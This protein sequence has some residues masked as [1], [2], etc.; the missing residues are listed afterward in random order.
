MWALSLPVLVHCATNIVRERRVMAR[1][2]HSDNGTAATAISVSNGE[3]TSIIT[4][5]PMT[6]RTDV[7]SWLTVIDTEVAM[8]STSL[9]TRLS[10]SPRCRESK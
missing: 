4:T 5:T 9:V 6:V 7:S 8:L 3:M 10:N 2:A 1:I